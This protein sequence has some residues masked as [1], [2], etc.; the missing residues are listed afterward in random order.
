MCRPGA[1]EAGAAQPGDMGLIPGARKC[2]V[3]ARCARSGGLRPPGFT[4]L[5]SGTTKPTTSRR[6][7]EQAAGTRSR[8]YHSLLRGQC[9]EFA[10][11]RLNAL[12][13]SH[14]H[15]GNYPGITVEKEG[16]IKRCL[17]FARVRFIDPKLGRIP[18]LAHD[19]E[20]GRPHVLRRNAARRGHR[21]YQ[22]RGRAGAQPLPGPS[23]F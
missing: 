17:P 19:V 12:T 15:V 8:S 18:R 13:G 16:F 20:D 14:Q 23:S 3:R 10:R 21:R 7:L 9:P 1:G 22:C 2:R 6:T 5:S 11:R 4:P